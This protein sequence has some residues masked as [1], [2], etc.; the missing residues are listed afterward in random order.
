MVF[1]DVG[2]NEGFY[3][4]FASRRV[5]ETG[6]VWALEPSRREMARLTANVELNGLTN[7]RP[8]CVALADEDGDAELLIACDEH[9]GHNTLGQ[10]VYESG[11]DRREPVR[12]R[13][14]DSLLQESA[15]ERLDFLKI[16]A[17]GAEMRVL[18]GAGDALRKFRPFIL[19]E[20]NDRALKAQGSSRDNVIRHLESQDYRIYLFDPATGLPVPAFEGRYGDNMLAVPVERNLPEPALLPLPAT[21]R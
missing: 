6:S 11:P 1:L 9:S 2:A 12:L 15:L 21:E 7:V 5:G 4:V 3:S 14:L 18:A 16:D 13:R 19:L 10:F 20:M 8:F 17:E